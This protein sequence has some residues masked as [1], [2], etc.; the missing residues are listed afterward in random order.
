MITHIVRFQPKEASS[1]RMICF[2]Y[3]GATAAIY[4]SWNTLM[5]EEMEL[6][7]VEIP[8]RL[9][10][11]DKPPADMKDL[12]EIL[13]SQILPFINKPYAI[14]GHSFGSIIAY[15]MVKKLQVEN[16]EL[17]K[18]LFVSS[19]RAPQLPS[20]FRHAAGLPD[21]EFIDEMQN[22]YQAIPE[23]VLKEKE[24]LKMLLPILK[25]DIGI[26]E[27]Y[28]GQLDPLLKVPLQT[29]YGTQDTTV[30]SQEIEAWSKV[31]QKDFQMKS[32]DGGHF[33]LD[34][35]KGAIISDM[36]SSLN[37]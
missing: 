8:G 29:Y 23:A 25:Q 27:T 1:S 7:A 9:H 12:I 21:P 33:F 34:K 30:N 11:K 2:P 35:E 32:F 10:L 15:E 28:I 18:K 26:N 14:F 24:L 37:L 6:V 19:R 36:A 3:A 16:L 22:L 13:Y 5:P 20:R 17:P 31:T 4:R